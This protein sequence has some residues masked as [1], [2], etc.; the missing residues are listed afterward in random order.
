MNNS[1]N[2]A[3][4]EELINSFDF[5]TASVDPIHARVAE[6]TRDYENFVLYSGKEQPST[7]ISPNTRYNI[8]NRFQRRSSETL[9]KKKKKLIKTIE[10][11]VR[12]RDRVLYF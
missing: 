4:A 9:R 10:L 1:L 7:G 5:Y 2:G 3:A 12:A 11:R 8:S 6:E